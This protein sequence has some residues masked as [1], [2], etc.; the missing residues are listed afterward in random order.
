MNLFE[1]KKGISADNYIKRPLL[2]S[3]IFKSEAE[4]DYEK[5]KAEEKKQIHKEIARATMSKQLI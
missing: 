2:T 1:I 4:T 3:D 5:K